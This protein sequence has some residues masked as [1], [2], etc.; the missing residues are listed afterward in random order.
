MADL[1]LY[2][3]AQVRDWLDQN[4]AVDGLTNEVIRPAFAWALIHNPF[5]KDEDPIVAAIF[6]NGEFAASTCAYPDVLD[7][8][9]C[10]DK[11]GEVRRIWFFPMLWVKKQH[12]GKGYGMIAIGSLAEIYGVE[13]AWTIR[14]VEESIIIFKYLGCN[15]FYFPRYYV[16][17][18]NINK[19]TLKGKLVALKQ[20][21]EIAIKNC[22]KPAAP[23]Y[24]YTLRYLT[25]VDK[26]SYDFICQHNK[27]HLIQESQAMLN[28]YVQYPSSISSLV[29]ERV[30]K[31]GAFFHDIFPMVL[32]SF[33]Q[34]WHKEMLVG[35]Y[36]LCIMNKALSCNYI[37]Y[38]Q[39]NSE[40]VYASVLEHVQ[41]LNVARFD[42]DDEGLA[43]FVKKYSAFPR[44]RTEDV[45]LSVSPDI[46]VPEKFIL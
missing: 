26:E 15:T 12:E 34:V 28:W 16:E 39:D 31:D 27:E 18:K 1:K 9:R 30:H 3:V 22:L 10:V 11:N 36:R 38:D 45:S 7:Y 21:C 42:T 17:E 4:I 46:K 5:V 23:H 35:V 25:N 19:S 6:D 32:N 24:D 40:V 37:Y 44:L 2:T 13:N 29:P 20:K 33:V 14:A 41:Q 8:P 43:T